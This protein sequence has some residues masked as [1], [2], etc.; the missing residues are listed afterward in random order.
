MSLASSEANDLNALQL[1]TSANPANIET[2]KVKVGDIDIAYKIF[3]SGKPLILIPGFSMTMDMWDPNML[4]GLSLEHMIVLFDNRGIGQTT[5]GNN[6]KQFS[7][8]QFANDTAGL[9]SALKIGGGNDEPVDILGI[10]LG[11][12]IAQEFALTY[13]DKVDRLMLFASNCGKEAIPPQ[14][15]FLSL[16][17]AKSTIMGN[18]SRDVFLS[19]LF[20]QQWISENL[21]YLEKYFAFSIGK[22]SMQNLILQAETTATWEGSCDRLSNVMNPTLIITG[23]DDVISPPANSVNLAEKIP[24]AWLVQ[25]KGGGHGLM[26]QYPDKVVEVL[27]T[28]FQVT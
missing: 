19:T 11:G 21:D 9:L 20:P 14:L 10:S 28:F 18:A 23:T 24:G 16:E 4:S 8:S 5:A 22:I 13:P 26:F 6:T 1:E 12:F 27:E 17:E 3:G 2:K 15:D 25:I 7:I